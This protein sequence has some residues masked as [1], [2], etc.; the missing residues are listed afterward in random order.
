[1]MCVSVLHETQPVLLR[2][3]AAFRF[4]F[5]FALYLYVCVY[6]CVWGGMSEWRSCG[7]Q[8]KNGEKERGSKRGAGE[9]SEVKGPGRKRRAL[10]AAEMLSLMGTPYT[11]TKCVKKWRPSAHERLT[12]RER[13][14]DE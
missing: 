6:V 11:P 7:S 1:M 8:L 2:Y 4:R 14:R 5:F 13:E 10:N 3:S 9:E 12:D